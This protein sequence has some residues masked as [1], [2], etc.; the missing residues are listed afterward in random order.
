MKIYIIGPSCVGKTTLA[1]KLSRKIRVKSIDLDSIFIDLERLKKDKSFEFVSPKDYRSR[2]DEILKT[3]KWIVEGVYPVEKIFESAD[4]IVCLRRCLLMPLVWQWKRYITDKSQRKKFG[5]RNN[6]SLSRD[7]IRQY[8]E[9][10][11]NSRIDE[12]TYFSNKKLAVWLERYKDKVRE[13]KEL[14]LI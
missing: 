13:I 10:C 5:F 2:I 7:I 12:P 11:D 8:F 6:L 4:I 9:R 14:D 1:R 3:D